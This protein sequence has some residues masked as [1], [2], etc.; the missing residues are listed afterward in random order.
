MM[1]P[2]DDDLINGIDWNQGSDASLDGDDLFSPSLPD[3]ADSDP[4]RIC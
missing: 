2:P 4:S 3:E 1:N